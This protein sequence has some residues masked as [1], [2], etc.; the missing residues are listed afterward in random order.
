MTKFEDD[1]I[2]LLPNFKPEAVTA[3]SITHTL[4][5]K[6]HSPQCHSAVERTLHSLWTLYSRTGAGPRVL[7]YLPVGGQD[8]LWW[9][10]PA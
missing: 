5:G 4:Y 9:E 2:A 3:A 8:V 7:A 1:I 6:A 10:E